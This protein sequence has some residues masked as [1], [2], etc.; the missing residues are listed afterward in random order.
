MLSAFPFPYSL[1]LPFTFLLLT[2]N[3]PFVIGSRPPW[4]QV[5]R[6]LISPFPSPPHSSPFQNHDPLGFSQLNVHITR[7]T[8]QNWL[9]SPEQLLLNSSVVCSLSANVICSL[10]FFCFNCL[11]L[12]FY[13]FF[14]AWYIFPVFFYNSYETLC[15]VSF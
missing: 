1:C 12:H 9:T 14:I 7:T 2:W 8:S 11:F 3:P 4:S 15:L 5:A 10:T 13:L 6:K